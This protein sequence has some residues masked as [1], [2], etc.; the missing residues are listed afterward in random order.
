[1]TA[2]SAPTAVVAATLRPTYVSGGKIKGVAKA[3]KKLT[4][5]KGTWQAVPTKV[6]YRF[7]W[8]RNGKRIKGATKPAYLVRKADKGKR[9]GCIVTAKNAAGTRTKA[10]PARKI[11]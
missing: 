10:L 8:T 7:Q 6:A 3:G 5:L 11:G 4:A 9:I 2:A 1:V